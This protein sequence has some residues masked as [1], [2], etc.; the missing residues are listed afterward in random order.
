NKGSSAWAAS[1][2]FAAPFAAFF[3]VFLAAVFFAAFLAA[4][5]AAFP[6]LP[7]ADG[8]GAEDIA[9]PSCVY[10]LIQ[11]KGWSRIRLENLEDLV[12][13]FKFGEDV[14]GVVV[15]VEPLVELEHLLR[16]LGIRN[17]GGILRHRD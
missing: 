9:S 17:H 14:H 7:F 12:V 11:R 2:A 10:S 3:A 13:N 4:F 16:D 5:L 1:T 15:F 8:P 6:G